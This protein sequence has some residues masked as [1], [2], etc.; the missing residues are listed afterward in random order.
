MIT[1]DRRPPR[2]GRRRGRLPGPRRHLPRPQGRQLGPRRVQPLRHEEHDHRR[3]RLRHHQR[4]PP[5]RLAPALPQPGDA[6]ALPPRDPRLQLPDDR[7]RRGHRP[8][9]ARRSSTATRRRRQAIAARYDAAFA[10][11][12]HPAPG[13][14]GRADAR[15][16]PVHDRGRPGPRR[17]RGRPGA[18]GRRRR[19][20]L[21]DPGPPPA[22]RPGA[23]HP[24]RPA[25]HRRGRRRLAEP[26]DLPGPDRRRGGHGHRGRAGG[27]R[28]PPADRA[29]RR[30]AADD[31]R[32]GR[33]SGTGAS[34]SASPVS[35]RWAAT[36][37]GS[38]RAGPDVDLVAIADPVGR[39]AR[40]GGRDERGPGLRRPA[41]DD[42]ARPTSTRSSSPPRPRPTWPLA[43]AAIE[44]GIAVLVEKPLAGTVD[45]ARGIVDAAA[46]AGVP[47]QVG[48]V[49]RF[50]PAVLELG[51]LLARRLA[52]HRLRD[53]Q[54]PGRPVPGP[55]PRRRRDR[56]PGHPRRRHPEL[57]RRRAAG[58]RL[59]RARPADPRHARGPPLRAAPLPVRRDR[60]ARRELADA[61]QAPPA[62]RSSARRGCSSSTTSPSDSPSPGPTS[63]IPAPSGGYAP[64]FAGDV[65]ELPVVERR[66]AR[67]RA[68]T[69]SWRVV[70]DGRP[71]GRGRRGRPVG[72]GDRQRPARGRRRAPAG[73]PDRPFS[74]LA[75]G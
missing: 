63:T 23:R 41:R 2:P 33:P 30:R 18:S 29:R 12:R 39:R 1:R 19:H 53:H 17:D 59:R 35:A 34:G 32:P 42:R 61:G 11:L 8:R 69:R 43:L 72:R 54:P 49:E 50:N 25:G 67:R 40:R 14:A 7:H 6:R 71:P 26:A 64:T 74:R 4:R 60:D 62:R 58:P 22:V 65:A 10:D 31:R 70:R 27:R 38:W 13:H 9:P 57:D 28:A 36:T 46:A 16:P 45:E 20:L 3:G 68:S 73:R 51:R 56:R 75:V 24:R 44:R 52:L 66:A 55:D 48:H 21:P 5:G 37:S 47:V 15:L